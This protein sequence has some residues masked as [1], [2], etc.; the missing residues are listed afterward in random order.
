MPFYVDSDGETSGHRLVTT[1]IPNGGYVVEGF[2]RKL[3]EFKITAYVATSAIE[4]VGKALLAACEVGRPGI[5]VLPMAG[6][7]TARMKEAKRN[8]KK[9]QLGYLGFDLEAQEE[10]TAAG[11]LTVNG[12]RS[13]LYTITAGLIAPLTAGFATRTTAAMTSAAPRERAGVQAEAALNRLARLRDVARPD[14][15]ARGVI[16]A[17]LVVAAQGIASVTSTPATFAAG[18][19]AA[20]QAFGEVADPAAVQAA[21]ANEADPQALWAPKWAPSGARGAEIDAA[22]TILMHAG[23]AIAMVEAV[24]R[25][26]FSARP[27]AAVARSAVTG[28][29]SRAR[30]MIAGPE[31]EAGL[32][33][34]AL[35]AGAASYLSLLAASLAPL[36]QVSAQ[37]P[38]PALWWSWFLHADPSRAEE[39]TARARAPHPGFMPLS[40]QTVA[41]DA[42]A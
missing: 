37:A 12:A 41:P 20:A 5:L 25:R 18:F 34:A 32:L 3:R 21:I 1:A 2:G 30:Q 6:F 26:E 11:G 24:S 9:D 38:L 29:V 33:L 35:D 31:S 36:V 10:W 4:V 15:A 39:I 40:F 14:A 23:L 8:Y 19:L 22:F 27:E 16:N 7:V 17:A 28:A 13:A 42:F